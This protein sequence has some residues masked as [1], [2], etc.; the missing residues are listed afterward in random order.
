MGLTPS[1]DTQQT[2]YISNAENI[3]EWPDVCY[4]YGN[5]LVVWTDLRNGVDRLIRA[6]RVTPQWAVLD[7]GNIVGSN[8][9]YQ[10]T[11][12]IAF[13]GVRFLVVWQNLENPYGIHCR[14]LGSDAL[15]Q[16]S[17]M[18]ISSSVT[19][20]NPR[21]VYGNSRFLIVW[22]EFDLT[23]NIVGRFVSPSGGLLGDPFAITSGSANH[24]S[25][26]LCYD[27]YRFL[28]VWS[29][30]TVYGQFVSDTGNLI[31]SAFPVS[32]STNEQVDPDVYHGS[33]EYLVIWSEFRTDYDVYGNMDVLVHVRESIR[34]IKL[35]RRI[36]PDKTVFI[37]RVNIIG[38]FDRLISV[39]DIYGNKVA[40]ARNGSWEADKV[41][42]GVYF[43]SVDNG[44]VFKLVKVK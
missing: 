13:D 18:T 34:D 2:F 38:G 12:V 20:T 1:C 25:P 29:Q 26:G 40:E 16:D 10:I 27:G 14:F 3:Q 37:E 4:G 8:A 7:T 15:P 17:I 39:F 42:A 24:V 23:N 6:A 9:D 19:A 33:D 30:N 32:S 35:D 11:P 22:Q 43:L 41:P 31:G 5:Y 36:Y 21:I 28:V 44:C